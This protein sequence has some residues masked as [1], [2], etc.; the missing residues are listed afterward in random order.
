MCEKI[1]KMECLGDKCHVCAF[2]DAKKASRGL[3]NRKKI[4]FVSWE[5]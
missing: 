2:S 1:I 3:S 4:L 5:V